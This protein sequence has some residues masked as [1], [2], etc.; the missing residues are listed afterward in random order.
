MDI[1]SIFNKASE[2][3]DVLST[4]KIKLT[5]DG[6]QIAR[7]LSVV[8]VSFTVLKEG[9]SRACSAFRNHSIATLRVSEKY[10]ELKAGQGT[11][12]QRLKIW[13][14]LSSET[15]SIQFSFF[16]VETKSF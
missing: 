5:G 7:G 8:N 12:L 6:T 9:Q 1:S 10:E 13:R 16:L 3:E 15:K 11:S 4:I 2:Q 14:C